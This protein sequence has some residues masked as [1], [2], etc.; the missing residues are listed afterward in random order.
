[1]KKNTVFII[2]LILNNLLNSFWI[3]FSTLLKKQLKE[4]FL[5]TYKIKSIQL[6]E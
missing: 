1:M 6:L 2:K 4:H 3:F 5:I